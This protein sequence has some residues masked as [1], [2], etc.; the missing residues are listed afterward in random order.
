MPHS[1]QFAQTIESTHEAEPY[2]LRAPSGDASTAL[3]S[4]SPGLHAPTPIR[5]QTTPRGV[6]AFGVL[7]GEFVIRTYLTNN[8]LTARD[9]GR[10]SID[11]VVTAATTLGPNEKFKLTTIQPD[12]T[13]IQTP[14]G[15]YVSAV[16]EGGLGGNVP[17]SQVLQTERT[18]LADDALFVLSGPDVVGLSTIGT[19]NGHFLTALGGGGKTSAA[20]HTDATVANTWE[21][22]WVLKSGDLGSGY[23]YAIRP[24]GTGGSGEVVN[25]LTAL[26]GGGRPGFQ[27]GEPAITHFRGLGTD[28]LFTLIRL[29]DGS[30][31]LQT[32]NG[33]N[34]V[35]AVG[36]GGIAHGDNLHT[37]ATRIQAWEKF[38]IV[39]QGDGT[40]TIQ[41]V[42]GFFLAVNTKVLQAT[43][44]ISTRISFPDA[45]PQIGY[46]AKFELMMIG[47]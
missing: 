34:Y 7:P 27:D 30:Y 46:T 1:D 41:T 13:T 36:G 42:S 9:G 20:F 16:G 31:A 2:R 15:Y 33:I 6:P 40:Y 28:S 21:A 23:R 38:R 29:D 17:A 12:Y 14:L 39:D 8:Y 37:D 44:G 22:F 35:T 26:G 43:G 24:A 47:T 4:G 32:S 25:F 3:E 45:A 5:H 11:A 19:F 10:H 18:S